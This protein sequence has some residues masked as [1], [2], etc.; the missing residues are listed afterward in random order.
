MPIRLIVAESGK[1]D[2]LFKEMY[3][4]T[5]VKDQ[6]TLEAAM[7]RSVQKRH[8]FWK[9]NPILCGLIKCNLTKILRKGPLTIECTTGIILVVTHLYNI[10]KN[11]FPKFPYWPDMECKSKLYSYTLQ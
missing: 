7:G 1:D 5:R 8:W 6:D 10:C 2:K 11:L 4:L 3:H 9:H